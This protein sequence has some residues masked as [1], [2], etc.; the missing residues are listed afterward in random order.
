MKKT[1]LILMALCVAVSSQAQKVEG[2]F[3]RTA[4]TTDRQAYIAG[5]RIWCSAFC[6]DL[7]DRSLSELSAV[8]YVELVSSRGVEASCKISLDRGRGAGFIDIPSSIPTGMYRLFAFTAQNKNE[9]GYDYL[10]WSV[11]LAIYN[12]QTHDRIEVEVLDAEPAPLQQEVVSSGVVQLSA[13]V[14]G[15]GL[16]LGLKAMDNPSASISVA[17]KDALDRHVAPFGS[18]PSASALEYED[19][20]FPEYDGEVIYAS[21][22][23]PDAMAFYDET[24][25]VTAYVSTVGSINDTYTGVPSKD[26]LIA[27]KT[28][29]IFG[30]KDIVSQV[31]GMEDDVDAHL[32]L[33]S[34][35]VVPESYTQE[36]LGI[37]PSMAASLKA[38]AE[39]A[40]DFRKNYS[41]SLATVLDYRNLPVLLPENLTEYDLDDYTR[42]GTM[43]EVLVEIVP[44]L[45]SRG[46]KDRQRIEILIA[47]QVTGMTSS[48]KPSLVL[49]DGVPVFQHNKV[50]DYD[51]M[52]VSKVQV[53]RQSYFYGARMYDGVVNFVTKS[54]GIAYVDFGSN[55]RITDFQGLC[56]PLANTSGY[57]S[58]WQPVVSL[59]SGRDV[60]FDVKLSSEGDYEIKVEGWT[61]GGDYFCETKTVKV[62]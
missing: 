25:V 55:V 52:L 48:W 46:R 33:Q 47:G 36:K 44:E 40:A 22:S 7:S 6:F 57:G 15:R 41:D 37:H 26:G 50:M 13:S 23:G 19:R 51:A 8:A 17:R 61:E 21:V 35:F 9:K 56:L 24:A 28:S 59:E 12:T 1:I 39:A 5:D 2:V 14:A 16:A 31:D 45:R 62:Q 60:T 20:V 32:V 18:M 53:W 30:A 43:K 11:P 4:L 58:W 54:G 38:R 3:E 42:F 34:P 27:F 29:N 49:I 10:D